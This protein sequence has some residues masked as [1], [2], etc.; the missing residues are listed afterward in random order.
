M[1]PQKTLCKKSWNV[2]TLSKLE[3]IHLVN[4]C[5]GH[6]LNHICKKVA[7]YILN[8]QKSNNMAEKNDKN[9]FFIWA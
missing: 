4:I 7:I 1:D 5:L 9:A 2:F 8:K 6:R 3:A